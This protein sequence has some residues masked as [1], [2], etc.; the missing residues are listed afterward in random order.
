[1][2]L[3]QRDGEKK[4]SGRKSMQEKLHASYNNLELWELEF[5]AKPVLEKN[6]LEILTNDSFA[7][8]N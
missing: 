8:F 3:G 4:I 5:V 2:A 6:P 7:D 1:V